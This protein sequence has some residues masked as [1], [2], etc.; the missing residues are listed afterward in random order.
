MKQ[1]T[2]ISAEFQTDKTTSCPS[3]PQ[4]IRAASL[5]HKCTPTQHIKMN[6][7]C[8]TGCPKMSSKRE[9]LNGLLV[10]TDL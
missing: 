10:N 3:E 9:N 5:L 2:N 6:T 8:N 4:A 7:S 1:R